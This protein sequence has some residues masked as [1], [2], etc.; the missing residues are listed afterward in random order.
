MMGKEEIKKR[1]EKNQSLFWHRFPH[2][3]LRSYNS[4][5]RGQ[6]ILK[7]ACQER[8]LCKL[9]PQIQIN[10]DTSLKK[11]LHLTHNQVLEGTTMPS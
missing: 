5:H 1:K 6:A 9:I 2:L 7:P 10:Y 3:S 4:D 8:A 11:I